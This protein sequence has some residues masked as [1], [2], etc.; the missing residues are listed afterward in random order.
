MSTSAR[1][2]PFQEALLHELRQVVA[3]GSVEPTTARRR[4][5][6]TVLAAAA[7]AALVGAG[8]ALPA[9]SGEQPAYAVVR[10]ANGRVDVRVERLADAAGLERALA[11]V[12]VA[13]DVTYLPPDTRCADGRYADATAPIA[14]AGVRFSMGDGVGYHLVLGPGAVGDRQTV[15]VAAS[16]TSAE[17]EV[18]DDGTRTLGGSWGSFGIAE[19]PVAPCRPVPADR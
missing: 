12:G 8:L 3:D 2:D 6:R 10:G 15:V 13:A 19:G 5:T 11:R 7:V 16:R 18:G 17:V 14:G 9:L 1:L 4:A